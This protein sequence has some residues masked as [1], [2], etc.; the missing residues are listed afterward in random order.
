M[1]EAVTLHRVR[2]MFPLCSPGPLTESRQED[3]LLLPKVFLELGSS[4]SWVKTEAKV[5]MDYGCYDGGT[6]NY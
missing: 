4:P 1:F 6:F 3:T 5:I 2:E